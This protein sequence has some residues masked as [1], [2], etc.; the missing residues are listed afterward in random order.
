MVV[1]NKIYYA[2]GLNDGN[3]GNAWDI[4]ISKRIDIYN[5]FS[6]IWSVDSLSVERGEMGTILANNK[7][8]W[9]GGY[10]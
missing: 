2:G 6:N 3:I 1:G 10:V 7:I 8:Y 4:W 5:A 9:A